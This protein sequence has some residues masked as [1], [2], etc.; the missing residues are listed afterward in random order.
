[1]VGVIARQVYEGRR[2]VLF[3]RRRARR[4]HSLEAAAARAARRADAPMQLGFAGASGIAG[5][6][7]RQCVLRRC[8][9]G[10]EARWGGAAAVGL[11]C[12]PGIITS[13]TRSHSVSSKDDGGHGRGKVLCPSTDTVAVQQSRHKRCPSRRITPRGVAKRN[14]FVWGQRRATTLLF[15]CAAR[16]HAWAADRSSCI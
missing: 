10:W 1:M 13:T 12:L 14:G 4:R 2:R 9:G 7:T 5:V 6:R 16:A 8:C 11:V 3:A 15:L